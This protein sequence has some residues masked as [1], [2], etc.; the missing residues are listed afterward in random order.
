MAMGKE[1]A[2]LQP[3]SHREQCCDHGVQQVKGD[4]QCDIEY[5]VL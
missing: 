2:C 4:A 1:L 5:V 3:Q